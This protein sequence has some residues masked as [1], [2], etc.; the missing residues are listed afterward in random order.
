MHI[1]FECLSICFNH[2]LWV[3]CHAWVGWLVDKEIKS[4]LEVGGVKLRDIILRCIQTD[5][6]RKLNQQTE[7]KTD[8]Y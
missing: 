7:T 2:L 4:Y 1:L 5:F 6:K 8:R 3:G